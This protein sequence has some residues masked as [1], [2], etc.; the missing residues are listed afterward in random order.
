ML[1]L[2]SNSS[3]WQRTLSIIDGCTGLVFLYL[4]FKSRD[5]HEGD[6]NLRVPSSQYRTL[7][8]AEIIVKNKSCASELTYVELQKRINNNYSLTCAYYLRT[9]YY[10]RNLLLG[11]ICQHQT[12][13]RTWIRYRMVKDKSDCGAMVLHLKTYRSSRMVAMCDGRSQTYYKN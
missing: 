9:A 6:R 13:R 5:H 1:R 10:V 3:L 2:N 4:C 8:N 7:S 11:N 12:Q